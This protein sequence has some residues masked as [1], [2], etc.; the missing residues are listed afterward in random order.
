MRP[1]SFSLPSSSLATRGRNRIASSRAVSQPIAEPLAGVAP[2]DFL[3][4]ALETDPL[5]VLQRLFLSAGGIPSGTPGVVLRL[6]VPTDFDAALL[7]EVPWSGFEA[8]ELVMLEY[9]V[10]NTCREISDR[11]RGAVRVAVGVFL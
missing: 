4:L 9:D 10:M 6:G 7:G 8:P 2:A 3:G 11:A 1:R 5:L